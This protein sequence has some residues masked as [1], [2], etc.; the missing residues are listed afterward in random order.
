MIPRSNT[1]LSEVK[2]VELCVRT[3]FLLSFVCVNVYLFLKKK[4]DRFF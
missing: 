3:T 4:I 2:V 1:F